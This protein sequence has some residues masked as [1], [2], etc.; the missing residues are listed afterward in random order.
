MCSLGIEDF[1]MLKLW[2]GL[3]RG[4][5]KPDEYKQAISPRDRKRSVEASGLVEMRWLKVWCSLRQSRER[6][7]VLLFVSRPMTG[8]ASRSE[9]RHNQGKGGLFRE[10]RAD[11]ITLYKYLQTTRDR[12]CWTLPCEGCYCRPDVWIVGIWPGFLARYVLYMIQYIGT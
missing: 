3:R 1:V 8:K 4:G 5:K 9:T 2:C 7:T 11:G 12:I 10:E 6:A